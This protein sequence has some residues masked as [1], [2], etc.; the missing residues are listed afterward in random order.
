MLVNLKT[1]TSISEYQFRKSFPNTIFPKILTDEIL[2]SFNY[3]NLQ[4]TEKPTYDPWENKLVENITQQEDGTYIQNW[5]LE[6][7]EHSEE[8]NKHKLEYE[9]EKLINQLDTLTSNNIS[10]GFFCE[11]TPP[12]TQKPETLFFSY[13]A[14]DQQNFA[15]AAI[16]ILNSLL[17]KSEEELTQAWNA[18]RNHTDSY[19]G[20]LVVLNLTFTTFLPIYQAAC[21][22]KAT[23]MSQG[24]EFKEMI[25]TAESLEELKLIKEEIF[26]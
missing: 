7:V 8:E 20:D 14:F 4:T 24:S 9:K 22:H 11:V 26:K 16:V 6:P 15:D 3:A 1:K 17:T 23:T 19:K 13:D 10:S 2:L 5:V 12:D 21:L 18:Y 25:R